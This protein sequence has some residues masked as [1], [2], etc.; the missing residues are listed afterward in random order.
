MNG[1][2]VTIGKLKVPETLYKFREFTKNNINTL[3][4]KEI[5]IPQVKSFNDPQDANL[6]FRYN[7]KEL[8]PGNIYKK[9][10]EIARRIFLDKDEA[11]IQNEAYRMQ[12]ENLLEDDQHLEKFDKLEY[13]KLNRTTGVMCLSPNVHNF[14]MWSYYSNSHTGFCIGYNT[15]KLIESRIFGMGGK[16]IYSDKFPTYP[17]FPDIKSFTFLNLLYTKSRVWK[18]EDEYRLLH[19]YK[20]GFVQ[21]IDAS[22]INEIVLGCKF[23]DKAGIDFISKLSSILPHIVVSQMKLKKDGFGLV[24]ETIID[25]KFLISSYSSVPTSPP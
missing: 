24:K 5:F 6:P 2:V 23:D 25:E 9:C 12:K 1:K 15:K 10:L 17:M 4:K 22:F 13:E 19:T 20:N 7:P 18:H 3:L 21:K 14:L 8:T 11:F 16:V